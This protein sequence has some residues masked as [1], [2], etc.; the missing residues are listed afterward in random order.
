M[1]K[2]STAKTPARIR[3]YKSVFLSRFAARDRRPDKTLTD[4]FIIID[5][6]LKPAEAAPIPK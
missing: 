2:R 4:G 1:G 5:L 6:F 3:P